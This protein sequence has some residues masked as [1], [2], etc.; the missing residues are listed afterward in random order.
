MRDEQY[1]ALTGLAKQIS[2]EPDDIAADA[3]KTIRWI[4]MKADNVLL[5]HA[6]RMQFRYE[7]YLAISK[8]FLE[9]P[10]N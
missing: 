10:E 5:S 1:N 9:E 4:L 6:A 8:V 7:L 2:G 3:E